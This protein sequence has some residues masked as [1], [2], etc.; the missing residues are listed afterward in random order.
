MTSIIVPVRNNLLV[1]IKC[2]DSLLEH[3]DLPFEIVIVDNG[4]DKETETALL[5]VAGSHENI[6]V[7]RNNLNLGW[8]IACNQGLAFARGDFIVLLNNDTE[9][10]AGW[11]PRLLAPFADPQV[12]LVGPMSDNVV[13]KTQRAGVRADWQRAA[14]RMATAK[15]GQSLEVSKLIGFCLAVRREVVDT[16]GGLDPRYGLGNFDDDDYGLRAQL[17]G[18]MLRVAQDC[19]VHHVG[20]QTFLSEGINVNHLIEVNLKLFLHKWRSLGVFGKNLAEMAAHSQG[21]I[22]RQDLFI[23]LPKVQRDEPPVTGELALSVLITSVSD[24]HGMVA[25]LL[26]DLRRQSEGKPVEILFLS[27]NR[28]RSLGSKRNALKDLARGRFLAFVDD[29][30]Q[31]A[32]DYVETI[33]G[34]I[35][36]NPAAD[37]VVF[38]L[39]RLVNGEKDRVV[40]F[41][42]EFEPASTPEVHYRKPHERMVWRSDLARSIPHPDTSRMTGIEAQGLAPSPDLT[43]EDAA[44][45]KAMAPLVRQ[46]VRIDR[47]L[48]WYQDRKILAPGAT[49]SLCVIAKDEEQYLEDCLKSVAGA[50]DEIC[51]VDTGSTDRTV[52][53][54]EKY[55]A[56]IGYH[57]WDGDFAAARNASL[58]LATCDWILV[59]DADERLKPESVNELR[60]LSYHPLE[61]GVVCQI[62]STQGDDKPLVSPVVRFFRNHIG[63]QYEGR[64]HEQP[65]VPGKATSLDMSG[66]R[67]LHLGYEPDVIKARGKLSRNLDMALQMVEE[68]ETFHSI[69]NLTRAYWELED[70]AKAAYYAGH[71]KLMAQMPADVIHA[72]VME[73]AAVA[74]EDGEKALAL[75]IAL[76][77]QF[78]AVPRVAFMVGKLLAHLDR[79]DEAMV[80]LDWRQSPDLKA[81]LSCNFSPPDLVS[82]GTSL[83]EACDIYALCAAKTGKLGQAIGYL[84]DVI[85]VMPVPDADLYLKL[86]RLLMGVGQWQ[87]AGETLNKA[88]KIEPW[89]K[90]GW[91]LMAQ[92]CEALGRDD[93]AADAR[94]NLAKLAA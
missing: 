40:K 57:A 11:L 74:A 51:V 16:I 3:T 61:F 9:V 65:L 66:I 45:A 23:P 13:S 19:F 2:I 22:G 90:A 92:I 48:Y 62:E 81:Y 80:A 7:I 25:P 28:R 27:D 89:N 63:V 32:A 6:R 24:R 44:W 64:L 79:F 75:S 55:G 31:V 56:K 59:L 87:M 93:L 85:V 17:S 43:F 53:I 42:V 4:S 72:A 47:V 33:L 73:V 41:G 77:D 67:I 18:F 39:M 37:L 29:D 50:V 84:N 26:A 21:K 88:L 71:A 38:D 8:P 35:E 76:R 94:G 10:T 58:A 54:A 14:D 78:P 52:E 49:I 60:W 82:A 1:T 69:F 86:V 46:Q 36:A 34:A 68:A 83:R 91:G 12:G 30:D 20:H 70:Y 15:A 5:N